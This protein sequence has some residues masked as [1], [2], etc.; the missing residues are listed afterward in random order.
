MAETTVEVGGREVQVSET[1]DGFEAEPVEEEPEG[2]YLRAECS[3]ASCHGCEVPIYGNYEVRVRTD[4]DGVRK[5]TNKYQ[6]AWDEEE[7]IADMKCGGGAGFAE[8]HGLD[9]HANVDSFEIV[10]Y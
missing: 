5:D 10:T 8:R 9:G 4:G 3:G 2:T 1:E 6:I 7:N